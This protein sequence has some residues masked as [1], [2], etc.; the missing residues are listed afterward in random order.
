MALVSQDNIPQSGQIQK[1]K[2][3]P[4]LG[5]SNIQASLGTPPSQGSTDNFVNP[6]QSE[7]WKSAKQTHSLNK[8][9]GKDIH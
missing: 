2:N 5:S 3:N 7:T 8:G 1:P 9:L 6:T 4:E